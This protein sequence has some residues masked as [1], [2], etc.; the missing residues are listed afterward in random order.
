MRFES[1]RTP[2][3]ASVASAFRKKL[4]FENKGSVQTMQ[5]RH[6]EG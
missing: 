6:H 3:E 2:P 4:R 5:R 1:V